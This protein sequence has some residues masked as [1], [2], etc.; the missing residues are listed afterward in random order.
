M[1][2][3]SKKGLVINDKYEVLDEIGQG[4]FSIVYQ[5]ND[6]IKNET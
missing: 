5:V 3:N 6:K 1:T 2:S 4:G